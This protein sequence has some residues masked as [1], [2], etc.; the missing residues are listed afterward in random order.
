MDLKRQ[1]IGFNLSGNI[2]DALLLLIDSM[3][4]GG[5][6]EAV[7]SDLA[8]LRWDIQRSLTANPSGNQHAIIDGDSNN[9]T[10]SPVL[11][12][13]T[14]KTNKGE[15]LNYSPKL[16]LER[17]KPKRKKGLT[18]LNGVTTYLDVKAGFVRE[19]LDIQNDYN[20]VNEFTVDSEEFTLDL[21]LQTYFKHQEGGGSVALGVP[22]DYNNAS[23]SKQIFRFVLE[24]EIEGELVLVDSVPF[25]V[26]V[27]NNT[28]T[29]PNF[30]SYG[31]EYRN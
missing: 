22:S 12:D 10:V 30:F 8:T 9:V 3:G 20:R 31:I 26:R 15:F 6:K 5:V 28:D 14:I 2:E 1:I 23:T 27:H 18:D 16:Y 21:K 24:L 29:D 4:A 19:R 11:I 13:V 7:L 17:Y 25:I